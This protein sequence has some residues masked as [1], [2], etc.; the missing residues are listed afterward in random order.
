MLVP[1]GTLQY[2]GI[3]AEAGFSVLRTNS[4]VP[5]PITGR[6]LPSRYLPP[7]GD[8]VVAYGTRYM[9]LR[10]CRLLRSELP[11][12]GDGGRFHEVSFEDRRWAWQ[13]PR[14][15]CSFNETIAGVRK[16]PK[17]YREVIEYICRVVLGEPDADLLAVTEQDYVEVL[18]DGEQAISVLET[19]LERRGYV[20]TLNL[21]DRLAVRRLGVGFNPPN[22]ELVMDRS[23]AA[24]LPI[25]PQTIYALSSHILFE[26]DL[27]LEPVG[28]EPDGT[29]KPIN[30]LSYKPANGPA[31]AP[32]SKENPSV[33]ANVAEDKRELANQCIWRM[34]RIK[35]AGG[36]KVPTPNKYPFEASIFTGA[37]T[38]RILPLNP[39]RI[40]GRPAEVLGYFAA[41]Q[42]S[43]RN[44]VEYPGG[45]FNADQ[46]DQMQTSALNPK[47]K[48]TGAFNI[49]EENG[50]VLFQGNV[51]R[52]GRAGN[53]IDNQSWL[54]AHIV[55]R[56]SFRHRQQNG[57][58]VRQVYTY[59]TGFANARPGLTKTITMEEV[60]Y[61]VTPRE[62]S[63]EG[64][65]ETASQYFLQQEIAKLGFSQ[66]ASV[67]CKGFRFDYGTDG[68]IFAIR[69][70]RSDSG[71]ATTIIDWQTERRTE[72]LTY[73]EKLRI[74]RERVMQRRFYELDLEQRKRHKQRARGR[75]Q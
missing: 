73:E 61:W 4:S 66:S 15:F 29:I 11:Q 40:G 22:D 42:T 71:Q 2:N 46:W 8:I 44:N 28:L 41:R 16:Y 55:L 3:H 12:G 1:Q 43:Y 32:W 18:S 64:E 63:S 21:Q 26:K 24:E 19:L 7:Y 35:G 17:T 53:V 70:E 56:T 33:F 34:Y 5:D 65:F 47:L 58:F 31:S 51:F 72:R 25:V 69:W 38:A 39:T 49:D 13:I 74:L 62:Q 54:P 20:V 14:L 75:V 27:L 23:F 10:N 37:D 60:P 50:I 9:T 67:P 59:Q 30:E 52:K 57:Q 36:F 48:F 68:R 45:A 6:F